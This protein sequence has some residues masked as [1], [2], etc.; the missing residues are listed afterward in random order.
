MLKYFWVKN[1]EQSEEYFIIEVRLCGVCGV[2]CSE[3]D[4]V[5]RQAA[6]APEYLFRLARQ[7]LFPAHRP[8]HIFDYPA[9]VLVRPDRQFINIQYDKVKVVWPWSIFLEKFIL[10]IVRISYYASIFLI[11]YFSIYWTSI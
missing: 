6:P 11:G 2:R 4:N 10:P 1:Q 9:L 5:T 8:R 7:P 3:A